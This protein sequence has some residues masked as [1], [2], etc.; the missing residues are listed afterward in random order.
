MY[1][2]VPWI[3]KIVPEGSRPWGHFRPAW[4]QTGWTIFDFTNFEYAILFVI[5]CTNSVAGFQVHKSNITLIIIGYTIYAGLDTPEGLN[6]SKIQILN[7]WHDFNWF[8]IL[9]VIVW[10]QLM[11]IGSRVRSYRFWTHHKV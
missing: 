2:F 9:R 11:T 1:Q 8:D 10:L 5:L 3:K 6:D 7:F 4:R